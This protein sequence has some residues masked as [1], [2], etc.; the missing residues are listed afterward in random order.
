MNPEAPQW[1]LLGVLPP[2][3]ILGIITLVLA[4]LLGLATPKR[5]AAAQL[6]ALTA[7]LLAGTLT[8]LGLPEFPPRVEMD[9]LIIAIIPAAALIAVGVTLTPAKH[10][11]WIARIPLYAAI[12]LLVVWGSPYLDPEARTGWDT[13]QRLL[14][15]GI[16]AATLALLRFLTAFRRK[17]DK[18]WQRS[19]ALGITAIAAAVTLLMFAAPGAGQTAMVLGGTLVATAVALFITPSHLMNPRVE[20]LALPVIAALLLGGLH[21][22]DVSPRIALT[23]AAALAAWSLLGL[24]PILNA[25][26]IV[27]SIVRWAALAALLGWPVA[28]AAIAFA[29]ASET[30][31]Y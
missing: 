15:L 14:Y 21:F 7:A 3:I 28:E 25:I 31:D 16:P 11:W 2:A 1:I 6:I 13:S 23:F 8:I 30:Y 29:Q 26:P 20:D 12:P 10:A 4:L 18:A 9:W 5:A 24:V 19:L 17:R 22:A 27:R